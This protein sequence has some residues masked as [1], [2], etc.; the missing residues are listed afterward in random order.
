MTS[1][2]TTEAPALD[3][4]TYG[5]QAID[6]VRDVH[7]WLHEGFGTFYLVALALTAIWCLLWLT[8]QIRDASSARRRR[9]TARARARRRGPAKAKAR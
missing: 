3:T 6:L 2:V 4:G 9:K 1:T 7:A 8:Q 5:Q